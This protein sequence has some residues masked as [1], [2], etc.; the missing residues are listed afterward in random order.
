MKN[1]LVLIYLRSLDSNLMTVLVIGIY[2]V[3]VI[4]LQ[5]FASICVIVTAISTL[6]LNIYKIVMDRKDRKSK[7]QN[8]KIENPKL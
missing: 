5:A 4:T 6:S 3:A 2:V 8:P 7:L 1:I